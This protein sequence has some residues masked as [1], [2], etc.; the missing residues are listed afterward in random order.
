MVGY[1]CLLLL[2][3]GQQLLIVGHYFDMGLRG[4]T[5]TSI[6]A[7]G[8]SQNEMLPIASIILSQKTQGLR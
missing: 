7:S 6:S 2:L 4:T 5:T 1:S 3:W 8:N